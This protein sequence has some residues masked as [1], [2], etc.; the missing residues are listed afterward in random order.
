MRH[1]A[2]PEIQ[3]YLDGELAAADAATLALH[4]DGCAR[5]TALAGDFR[6]RAGT[7]ALALH[8]VDRTEPAHWRA[9][10]ARPL[11]HRATARRTM[12]LPLRRAAVVLLAAAGAA[13]AGI[14]GREAITRRSEAPGAGDVATRP[15][16]AP[17]AAGV[18][19]PLAGDSIAIV[20]EGAGPAARVRVRASGRADVG[21]NV[22]GGSATPRFRVDARA[23]RIRVDLR[24]GGGLV[25]VDVPAALRSGEVRSGGRVVVRFETGRIDPT[26][27]ESG[28]PL[29]S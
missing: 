23:S 14:V 12:P 7:L 10:A 17:A 11:S 5:C 29:G 2:G 25:I 20:I 1:P 6:A 15:A 9:R 18:F 24:G 27:A 21:V 26:A 4:L 8:A 13:A 19:M 22:E 28:V 3:A 16:R